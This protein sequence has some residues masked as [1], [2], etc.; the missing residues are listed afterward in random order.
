M[1]TLFHF[2]FVVVVRIPGIHPVQ[3]GDS[4]LFGH[5]YEPQSRLESTETVS[6]RVLAPTCSMDGPRG[7]YTCRPV[8]GDPVLIRRTDVLLATTVMLAVSSWSETASTAA[9]TRHQ[10]LAGRM[11]NILTTLSRP[12]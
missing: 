5:H 9:A 11:H 8:V 6:Q 7:A 10:L 12:F 3:R 1:S 4:L 2:L